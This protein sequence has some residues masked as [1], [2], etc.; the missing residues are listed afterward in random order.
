MQTFPAVDF[1]WS[2][3]MYDIPISSTDE[4]IDLGKKKITKIE[5][6]MD[7]LDCLPNVKQVDMYKSRLEEKQER[8]AA[9]D[10]R[11]AEVAGEEDDEQQAPPEDRHGIADKG[12]PHQRLVEPRSAL[13]RRNHTRRNTEQ[14]GSDD[15]TDGQFQRRRKQRLEIVQHGLLRHDRAAKVAMHDLVQ[16]IDEL[17]GDGFVVTEIMHDLGVFFFRH[18][19]LARP[20]H[21]RVPRKQAEKPKNYISK[22]QH[23]NFI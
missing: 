2:F 15:R 18:H 10:G 14:D 1:E 4:K 19:P 3:T 7:Y 21:D 8:N 6:L 11:P 22:K 13:H 9:R 16:I 12:S 23:K 17:K 20:D 5:E